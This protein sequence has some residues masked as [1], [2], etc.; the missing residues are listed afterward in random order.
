MFSVI[1][2]QSDNSFLGFPSLLLT[3]IRSPS[4][5]RG[6]LNCKR[7]EQKKKE[8]SDITLS[9]IPSP[10]HDTFCHLFHR[11]PPPS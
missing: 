3:A 2:T 7:N 5:K 9:I 8:L 10:S 4:D 1:M 6:K 11:P